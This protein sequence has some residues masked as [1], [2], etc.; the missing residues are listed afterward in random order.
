VI[1]ITEKSHIKKINVLLEIE[2][3]KGSVYFIIQ[4]YYLITSAMVTTQIEIRL[5]V[6]NKMLYLGPNSTLDVLNC[7]W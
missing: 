2:N 7:G 3:L 4:L 5:F 6:E 1:Y